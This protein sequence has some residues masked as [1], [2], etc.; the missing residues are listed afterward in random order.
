MIKI[1]PFCL[2]LLF[3]TNLTKAQVSI[4]RH[5][6][7]QFNHVDRY[8]Y[9]SENRY[10]TSVKPYIYQQVDT[11]INIDSLYAF[12]FD[13][14]IWKHLFNTSL[15]DFRKSKNFTFTIDPLFD[16][17]I[18]KSREFANKSSINMR[19]LLATATINKKF[20]ITTSFCENQVFFND[21][22]DSLVQ[23]LRTI[24]GQGRFK[25]FK[26]TGYDYGFAEG[27]LSYNPN[28]VFNI[29][30]GTGK[31]FFGD[32]YRSLILSDNSF[33]YPFLKIT[34]DIWKIKYV[35][36][37]A[38]FQDS[39]VADPNSTGYNKKWG[40][41]HY[42]DWTV[43]KWFTFSFFEA[44]IWPSNDT[45]VGYRGFDFYYANPVVFYRPVEFN[46]GSPDNSLMGLN[47]KFTFFKN[48]VFYAQFM[49][50][51]FKLNEILNRTGWW[52]NK[53]AIQGG[54]KT[55][56][57][58]KIK[59]LDIQT[60]VNFVRPFTYSHKNGLYNYGNLNQPLAHPLGANFIESI[61]FLKYSYKRFFVEARFS[62][63]I[64]GSDTAN[65][66]FGNDIY[67]TY[68]T[69]TKDYGN[70]IGQHN[71]IKVAL[72]SIMLSYLVNPATNM[73]VFFQYV[74]R[75]ENSA[76]YTKNEGLFMLGFRTALNNFYYD[77]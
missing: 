23:T 2:A 57:L 15:I 48:Y 62:Y 71:K 47:L 22:R 31:H 45:T 4:Y 5:T 13:K 35:N 25:K 30:F 64:H 60:E 21:Y 66:N 77:F 65:S 6:N 38:Q 41:F 19:G 27:Y 10:H 12:Q 43:T 42:L 8:L 70:T 34:T 36:L 9:R 16:F 68:A 52:A 39:N 56:D 14:P 55:F 67:K 29:Q 17:Q 51:E 11:I 75:K 76:L 37:W 7:T 26:E 44:V 32:G 28:N 54:F 74:I 46:R 18:G 61:S 40:A 33:S 58:L 73:N 72:G 59:H 63:A 69:R 50:D 20:S 3:I 53:Y 1:V 49:F 24:P